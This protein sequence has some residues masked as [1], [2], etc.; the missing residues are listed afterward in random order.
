MKAL[1][2]LN[3]LGE[4]RKGLCQVNTAGRVELHIKAFPG[5]FSLVLKHETERSHVTKSPCRVSLPV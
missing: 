1:V 3:E 2:P 5:G 4:N